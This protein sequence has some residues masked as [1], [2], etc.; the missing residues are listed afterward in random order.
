M[1]KKKD[2]GKKK[3][4]AQDEPDPVDLI[5]AF[6]G[7]IPAGASI[8]RTR[9]EIDIF[10]KPKAGT[11]MDERFPADCPVYILEEQDDWC[12]IK[13]V[14]I[15]HTVSG[16]VPRTALVFPDPERS[17]VFPNIVSAGGD[18][19]A[20]SV[21]PSVKL[22]DFQQWQVAGGRPGWIADSA[23]AGLSAAFQAELREAMLASIQADQARWDKWVA[24]VTANARLDEAEMKEWI[25]TVDGGR[26]VY[27]LR[28][29]YVYKEPVQNGSYHGSPLK[30]QILRWNG[31]VRFNVED[32]KRIDFYEVFAYRGSRYMPGW[33]RADLV[34]EYVFPTPEND[35]QLEGNAKTV[36]DLSKDLIRHP[37]DPEVVASKIKWETTSHYWGAQYIDVFGATNVH[38]ATE[39]VPDPKHKNKTISTQPPAHWSLCGEF[40]VAALSGNDILP[41]LAKWSATKSKNVLNIL[42]HSHEGTGITDLQSLLALD[43]INLKNETY[44]SIPTT[45]QKIKDRLRAGQFAITGCGIV[46]TGQLVP[47]GSIR[48]WVVIVDILPVGTSGWVRVYN[49]FSNGEEVYEYNQ[50]LLSVGTGGGIWV[51]PKAQ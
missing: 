31:N 32:G 3:D 51:F 50:F 9:A 38:L 23:W 43:T 2:Q 34:E 11:P 46:K 36:F 24:T 16:F 39:T 1:A 30:G 49:P 26:E 10:A 4:H 44:P 6:A 28:D 47:D 13:P 8:V 27:A 41:M 37:Q 42:S 15:Q 48:H 12:R 19:P 7:S 45:P 33:F 5:E 17:S 18:V 35:P 40:C 22:K 29:H 20:P 25:V 21:P 14:R